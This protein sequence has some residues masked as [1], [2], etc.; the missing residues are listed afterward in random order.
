MIKSYG[1]VW[2]AK[3]LEEKGLEKEAEEWLEL[4]EKGEKG[5]GRDKFRNQVH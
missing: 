2:V 1:E 4:R 5:Y 3:Y